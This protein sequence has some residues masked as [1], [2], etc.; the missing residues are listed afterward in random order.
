MGTITSSGLYTAL[1][2]VPA[3][4][5]AVTAKGANTKSSSNS[6]IRDAAIFAD[7][8]YIGGSSNNHAG[9]GTTTITLT[10][11][12]SSSAATV[13]VNGSP[14]PTTV[15]SI[16]QLATPISA[17]SLA[18]PGTLSLN[19]FNPAPERQRGPSIHECPN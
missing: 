15:V 4:S 7:C 16:T 1:N 8:R 12:P 2:E 13:Y 17:A 11:G 18:S 5:I 10:G 19:A 9:F 6:A 14:L 3:G